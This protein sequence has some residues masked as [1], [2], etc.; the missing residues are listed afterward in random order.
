M[1]HM[2]ILVNIMNF[3]RQV[4][5]DKYLYE[6]IED[7]KKSVSEEEKNNIFKLFCSSIWSCENKRRTYIKTIRFSVRK[8]L[9]DTDIGKIFNTWSDVE[10][11]GYKSMTN[12][13]DW[14]HL[15]RQK[16]NNIYT[17]YFDS[18]VILN[19][20]YMELLNTPKRLYYQWIDGTEMN[21]N[22]LTN[23]INDALY[24]AANLKILY[25]KQKMKL[26]WNEYKGVIDDF[27]KR[28]LDNCELIEVFE[29]K[30]NY[31]KLYDFKNEDNFYIKYFCK[32]LEGN[33]LDYQK[34]YYG[35]KSSSRKGYTR[36]KKC[37]KLIVKTN[38]RIMYCSDCSYQINK[39]KTRENMKKRRMFDLEK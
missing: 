16:V 14:I 33:I 19:S 13:T 6:I 39:E 35:L 11:V 30:N 15:I 31:C 32:R 34:K 24:D 3:R 25:Q 10:Y 29:E 36:C 4:N 18:S 1:I 22:V 5:I 8:D 23:I 26:S 38:N 7:Y 17:R 27:F 2:N 21:S 12:K 9:L 28:C 37:G 20:D